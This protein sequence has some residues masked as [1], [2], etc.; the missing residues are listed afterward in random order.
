[1][2]GRGGKESLM[3][4]YVRMKFRV[5]RKREYFCL[6]SS[7]DPTPLRCL[8]RLENCQNAKSFGKKMAVELTLLWSSFY[9]KKFDLFFPGIL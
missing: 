9:F 3:P 8:G 4:S 5:M 2:H 1:M 7:T 6:V